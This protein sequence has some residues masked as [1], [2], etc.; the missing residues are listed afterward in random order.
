MHRHDFVSCSC[1]TCFIDGGDK[2]FRY[3]APDESSFELY[4]EDEK[5][6][7]TLLS[8]PSDNKSEF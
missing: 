3:G 1:G 2:Y 7:R 8:K 6:V 4:M 5:G